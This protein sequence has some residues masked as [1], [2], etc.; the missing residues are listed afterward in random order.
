MSSILY[1]M[2]TYMSVRAHLQHK[3]NENKGKLD[4]AIPEAKV[5]A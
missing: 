1:C 4:N 3:A 5:L 2:M